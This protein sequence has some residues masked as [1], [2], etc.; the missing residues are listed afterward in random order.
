MKPT[1]FI[2]FEFLLFGSQ[3]EKNLFG[4]KKE[5]QIICEV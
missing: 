4:Y 5:L 1:I 2:D 3:K